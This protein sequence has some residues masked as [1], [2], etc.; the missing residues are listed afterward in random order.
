M[1]QLTPAQ[2]NDGIKIQIEALK[3]KDKTWRA[4]L[5]VVHTER[6]VNGIPTVDIIKKDQG[7]IDAYK[8]SGWKELD[9]SKFGSAPAPM[10]AKETPKPKP[11]PETVVKPEPKP[12][13]AIKA[14]V[15]PEVTKPQT[16]VKPE[17]KPQGE[18]P[19]V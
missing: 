19:K 9:I 6:S 12:E 8:Q 2:I 13:P 16:P 10:A 5:F 18:K 15:K 4:K 3:S 1:A 14:E 11:Q 17:V 7:K